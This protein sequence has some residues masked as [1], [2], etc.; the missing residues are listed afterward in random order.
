MEIN[1]QFRERFSVIHTK[2]R[3][4]KTKVHSNDE[5][6]IDNSWWITVPSD[7]DTVLINAARDLEDYFFTSM[8]L[9]LRFSKENECLIDAKR[10]A[11]SVLSDLKKNTYKLTVTESSVELCGCDSRMAA[12]AGYFVEDLM[13][14][15]EAPFLVKESVTRE[16]LF[17]PR[18]VHSGYGLDMFPEEHLRNIAH[19]GISSLL[20]FVKDVDITP[21]G[22]H[23]FNDLCK[24][25]AAWG[26][27]VYAYSYLANLIHP[28]DDRAE[29]FYENLYG[30][31][32]DRCP[33]FKGIIFVG[34]S[35][36]F[37]SKDEHSMGIR[38]K[39]NIDKEGKAI[40]PVTKPYP[41]WWP[42]YDYTDWLNLVKKIIFK[43]KPDADIVFWSYNWCRTP[44]EARRALVD[45]LPKDISLQATYEM[46]ET[47]VR[48]GIENRT[49]D[50]TLF[51]PGPGYYFSTEAKFAKDNGLRFY[52]MT[53]TGG[54]TWDVG[55]IPY[56]PA[57]Y[58]WMERYRGMIDAH[59]KYSL[60][61]T[62]DSHHYGFCPSFISDL[63]KWA[64]HS[65][66]ADLEEVLRKIVARDFCDE[67]VDQVCEGYR[68]YS[69]G[70]S[71]L[72]STERDQYGPFRIGPAYP[73][74]LFDDEKI[75]IPTT[76]YA[77]F[78]GNRI[79]YPIYG[80]TI[81]GGVLRLDAFD[82]EEDE[83]I[84]DY[85]IENFKITASRFDEGNK[86][87]EAAI[88]KIP[89]RKKENAK[90]ILGI[91]KFICNT[92]KTAVN[93]KYF[94]KFKLKVNDIHGEERNKAV[95]D[96]IELCKNERENAKDTL[97]LV[98]F[99]SR[100]GYEPTME[101]MCDPAHILWKIDQI[102]RVIDVELPKYFE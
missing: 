31:L 16:S 73:F 50:Y 42:C 15:R 3:W 83:K 2:D 100:L 94:F 44:A 58:L 61:G 54:A 72:I 64:F 4:D 52:S 49:T 85:E 21:H 76:P 65:P 29:E 84:F 11:Y 82:T 36:E 23:D 99:D 39:D 25:A 60:C 62:M 17:N 80:T 69:E 78:G 77:H 89:E 79:C 56:V 95:S 46:G 51:F 93:V 74:V 87:I 68:L 91:G 8:G 32:F 81:R 20:V 55:V 90:R 7:A 22:Y 63:A 13:N 88:E 12:Q 53:N 43:R 101:Y 35:C 96:M 27:D 38:R 59:Y 1:Y 40:I 10:I 75:Q 18:M 5:L 97:P 71:H 24:R 70:I 6:V 37:P 66:E 86:L 48:D 45:S 57:P 33:Y 102:T 92:A 41:G 26:L 30:R 19:S 28:D 47:V 34:E 9:S 98:E 67:V 14:L